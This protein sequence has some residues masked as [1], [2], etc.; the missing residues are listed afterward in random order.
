[1]ISAESSGSRLRI[2]PLLQNQRGFSLVMVLLML[3]ILGLSMGV[4]G[5]AWSDLVRRSREADLLWKGGQ[6]RKAIEAYYKAPHGQGTGAAKI[7]P[8]ELE[9]LLKD[10][11]SLETKRYLR[12]LYPDPMTG[13]D[14][15]LIKD[16]GGR[17]KG[18]RSSLEK[19]PFKTSNFSEENKDFEGRKLYSEWEF[20][21]VPKPTAA[22]QQPPKGTQ[23]KSSS[24]EA[25][26]PATP[27][28]GYIPGK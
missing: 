18:V 28:G 12:R 1:M 11:R 13:G 17:I 25:V 24:D 26:P 15:I 5:S 14:W 20:V 9:Y 2:L 6:I 21:Y 27:G 10:P 19:E 3:V 16:Q 8:S 7:Y 22:G 4:A 23:P